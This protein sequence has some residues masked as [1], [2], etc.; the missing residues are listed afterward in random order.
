MCK[1]CRNSRQKLNLNG[2]KHA[3]TR[4]SFPLPRRP[5]HAKFC[6]GTSRTSSTVH[7]ATMRGAPRLLE[8]ELWS[9]RCRMSSRSTGGASFPS[10]TVNLRRTAIIWSRK[11]LLSDT[12]SAATLSRCLNVQSQ[13]SLLWCFVV[14]SGDFGLL[15]CFPACEVETTETHSYFVSLFHYHHHHHLSFCLFFFFIRKLSSPH[16]SHL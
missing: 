9:T 3:N 11:E 6:A 10:C 2:K 1:M 14:A 4:R 13:L 16:R 5:A 15:P 12:A 8:S 7:T